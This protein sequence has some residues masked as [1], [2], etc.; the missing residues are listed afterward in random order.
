LRTMYRNTVLTDEKANF[1]ART[2]YGFLFVPAKFRLG[3]AANSFLPGQKCGDQHHYMVQVSLYPWRCLNNSRQLL[4]SSSDI[5]KQNLVPESHKAERIAVRGVRS[6]LYS[7]QRN[8]ERLS[9]Q[10]MGLL[11]TH[12]SH[13]FHRSWHRSAYPMDDCSCSFSV[14]CQKTTILINSLSA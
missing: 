12:A 7:I 1:A 6:C 11:G 5:Q 10:A 9:E 3:S 14:H 13:P 4:A 8:K 2:E